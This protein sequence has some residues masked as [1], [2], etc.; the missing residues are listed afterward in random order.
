[1]T[2]G[3]WKRLCRQEQA[4]HLWAFVVVAAVSLIVL[5][6]LLLAQIAQ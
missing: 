4:L 1:M 3:N 6:G 2:Q 5:A